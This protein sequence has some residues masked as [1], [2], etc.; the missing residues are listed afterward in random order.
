MMTSPP[1]VF[2]LEPFGLRS[3]DITAVR[4]FVHQRCRAVAAVAGTDSEIGRVTTALADAVTRQ[5]EAAGAAHRFFSGGYQ[6]EQ[7]TEKA[8]EQ[9]HEAWGRL[10]EMASPW[11]GEPG[12]N[13]ACWKPLGP[14]LYRPPL[15][16]PLPLVPVSEPRVGDAP[17]DVTALDRR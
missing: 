12:W 4:E 2:L 11:R 17:A 9:L 6:P 7:D 8:S 5:A 13:T 16:L 3:T 14:H 15:P 10:V 1:P